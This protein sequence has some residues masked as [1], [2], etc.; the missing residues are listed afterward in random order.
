[1]WKKKLHNTDKAIHSH[2]EKNTVHPVNEFFLSKNLTFCLL[3]VIYGL[4]HLTCFEIVTFFSVLILK[5]SNRLHSIFIERLSVS[6]LPLQFTRKTNKV[7]NTLYPKH[8]SI[9]KD[10]RKADAIINFLAKSIYS[11][12]I[13]TKYFFFFYNMLKH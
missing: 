9:R 7:E 6:F 5:N 11:N 2:N 13:H 12:N 8:A 4:K 3:F 1:M 10:I